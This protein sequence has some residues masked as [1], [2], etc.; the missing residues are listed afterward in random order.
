MNGLAASARRALEAAGKYQTAEGIKADDWP[1]VAC[2]LSIANSQA[3]VSIAESLEALARK[4]G[5][6]EEVPGAN[7]AYL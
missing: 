7:G 1:F 5:H 3:Q 6:A 4:H 2:L